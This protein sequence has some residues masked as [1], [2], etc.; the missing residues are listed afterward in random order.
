MSPFGVLA[1]AGLA[2]VW[3]RQRFSNNLWYWNTLLDEWS[4]YNDI[5]PPELDVASH[6]N[7]SDFLR[8]HDYASGRGNE[9]LIISHQLI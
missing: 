2:D 5:D 8:L 7:R 1:F 4:V 9:P 6:R 3:K